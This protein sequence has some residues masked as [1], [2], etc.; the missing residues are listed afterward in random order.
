MILKVEI[1]KGER[2]CST[3]KRTVYEQVYCVTE[4][5]EGWI[6]AYHHLQCI[7]FIEQMYKAY[8]KLYGNELG[9]ESHVVRKINEELRLA[10]K[11]ERDTQLIKEW[12]KK[13]KSRKVREQ[14]DEKNKLE[15]QKELREEAERQEARRAIEQIEKKKVLEEWGH[16]LRE[17]KESEEAE[18]PEEFIPDDKPK[19]TKVDMNEI[20]NQ[21]HRDGKL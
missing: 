9:V 2:Q 17:R 14:M 19:K 11:V 13:T 8:H 18:G 1:A 5:K 3:C 15:L 21:M 20:C 4:W 6:C 12:D 16:L 10:N 7:S